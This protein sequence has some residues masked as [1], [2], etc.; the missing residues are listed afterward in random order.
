MG[1]N[2]RAKLYTFLHELFSLSGSQQRSM[3]QQSM[4]WQFC[5]TFLLLAAEVVERYAA[6][7]EDGNG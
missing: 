6:K 4:V 2:S 5:F 1:I 3:E 7:Q